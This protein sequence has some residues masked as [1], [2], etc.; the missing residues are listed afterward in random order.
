L[1]AII[2]DLDGVIPIAEEKVREVQLQNR[3]SFV[4]DD[5]NKDELP[6]G[7]DLALHEIILC[8]ILQ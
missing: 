4:A 7:C 2:Y 3:V 1:Q 6:G 5:Y 8:S